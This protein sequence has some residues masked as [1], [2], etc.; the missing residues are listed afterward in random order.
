MTR[1]KNLTHLAGQLPP[2]LTPGS[3]SS[4]DGKTAL[5]YAKSEGKA[6]CVAI[7]E[8]KP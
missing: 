1:L 5:D 3:N 8:K 7:L 4:Q 2:P 6:G